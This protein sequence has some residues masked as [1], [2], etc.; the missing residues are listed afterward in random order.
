MTATQKQ[1]LGF[2]LLVFT[3]LILGSI[4][5]AIKEAITS[6]SPATQFA[7]RF[8]IAAIILTPFLRNLNVKLLRDGAIL[9]VL[10]FGVFATATIGLE[11]IYANEASFIFGLNMVFVT[12][13]ELLFRKRLS[14]RAVLA[15]ILAFSGIGVMS[16]K[17]GQPAIGDLWLLGSALGDAAYIIVLEAFSPNHSSIPLVT[18]QLWVVAALGL[19]WAAPELTQHLEAIHT[20]LGVLVYLGVVATVLV[21]LFQTLAQQWIAAHEVALFLALEPVFGAIFAFLLLGETFS[22]RSFI[23]A[24]MVLIGI[25]LTL[26]RPKIEESDLQIPQLLENTVS[27]ITPQKSPVLVGVPSANQEIE[28]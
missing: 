28:E 12:L 20:N 18:I 7:I 13:F 23:G 10:L 9:G 15:V 4:P 27:D 16:W 19:L 2:V 24:A 25:I 6:L 22:T 8:T 21:I 11:T 1:S 14:V 3:A 5:V 26:I 17:S